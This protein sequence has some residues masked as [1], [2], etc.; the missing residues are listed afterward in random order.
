MD[1]NLLYR[2]LKG[3]E[4]NMKCIFSILMIFVISTGLLSQES[5]KT[6][7]EYR[8]RFM[9][10]TAGDTSLGKDELSLWKQAFTSLQSKINKMDDTLK[11]AVITICAS[12][13]IGVAIIFID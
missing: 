2:E 11:I 12:I 1:R 10:L 9:I 7:K 3:V 4:S 6:A 5:G 8:P 13:I